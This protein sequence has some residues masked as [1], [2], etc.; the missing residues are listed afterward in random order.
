MLI[1]TRKPGEGFW[2]G[3]QTEIVVFGWEGSSVKIGVRAPRDILVLRSELKATE[4][5]NRAA[6]ETHSEPALD[7][8]AERFRGP[9]Q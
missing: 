9:E 1:L 2:I 7:L 4:Q 5:Q 6:A 3:D 8:L